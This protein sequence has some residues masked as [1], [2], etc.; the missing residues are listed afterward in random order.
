MQIAPQLAQSP[1]HSALTALVSAWQS[2]LPGVVT[3]LLPYLL[4][5]SVEDL[6]D[7]LAL[8]AALS[9]HATHGSAYAKPAQMLAGAAALDMAEWWEDSGDTYLSRVS[10]A[11]IAQ[12]LTEAG[13]GE[14]SAPQGKLKKAQMVERAE[15]LLHGKRWLPEP[16]RTPA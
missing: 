15:V 5:L 14:A 11:Q 16:L 8:C 9:T 13:E 10:K 7:L 12:A 4:G 2:R 3:D 6:L 1:A